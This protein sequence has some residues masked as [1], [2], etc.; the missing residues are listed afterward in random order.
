MVNN[1][2]GPFPDSFFDGSS[3][4][5]KEF[6]KELCSS[7]NPDEI[8]IQAKAEMYSLIDSADISSFG[9]NFCTA[10]F[11][12]APDEFFI[13]PTSTT[14]KYHGG[15]LSK[16]NS[17]GGNIYHTSKVLALSDK[18]LYRYKELLDPQ[19]DPELLKV[20]CILHDICKVPA[21]DIYSIGTHGEIGADLIA[22]VEPQMMIM[23]IDPINP[24]DPS[25]VLDF[26]PIKFA[27]ANHMY[28]WKFS[29]VYNQ[30]QLGCSTNLLIGLMLAECDYFATPF[31]SER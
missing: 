28:L 16:D 9:K 8:L 3:Q 23:T 27:V 30:L 22:K 6:V 13:L 20:S 26:E 14:G 11:A 31:G 7:L 15:R 2:F 21:G 1:L 10:C 24:I 29:N 12:K 25:E 5:K 18:V 17:L 19:R 4:M